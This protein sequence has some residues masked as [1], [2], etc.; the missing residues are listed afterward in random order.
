MFEPKFTSDDRPF[1]I[2][3]RLTSRGRAVQSITRPHLIG[4]SSQFLTVLQQIEKIGRS[5]AIVLIL[6]ET[7][8]GKELVARA[9]H[10]TSER[11]S[12]PFVA[13]NCGAVPDSLVET[14][15]FGHGKG[16]FTDAKR[17]RGGVVAHAEGGTLFLDEIDALSPKAQVSMLRFLQ[18]FRYR[19]IG[20]GT[21]IAADVRILAAANRDLHQLVDEGGFR[22]DLFFR[23]NIFEL[24]IPPLRTRP[25]DVELLAQHFIRIFSD[26]YG[27]PAKRVHPATLEWLRRHEW[28]GNVRELENWVHR[29][30]L[31][32]DGD[33][34]HNVL[35]A[36]SQTLRGGDPGEF[37]SWKTA[38]AQALAEFE[39]RYV[40]TVLAQAN[41]NVTA[42]AR[43][44]GKDRRAFG[45]LLKKH[46]IDK[47]RY[48]S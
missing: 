37:A 14:E 23:L 47:G 31:L 40:A 16:A 39:T 27:I 34:I 48:Q 1:R 18:D 42:A 7:G 25:E 44:A 20:T 2:E 36:E 8:S 6:G 24:W 15:L 4:A 17:A 11:S 28:P 5:D 43:L 21:E 22:R 38:R 3:R 26:R 9:I 10:W 30:L 29:A 46:G 35:R 12:G 32:A 41:G 13:V 45:R 33:E 19:P